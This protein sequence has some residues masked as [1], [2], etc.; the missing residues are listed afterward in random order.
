[1]LFPEVNHPSHL[2][3]E[4]PFITFITSII[5]PNQG[6]EKG[7][8]VMKGN[9]EGGL[10]AVGVLSRPLAILSPQPRKRILIKRVIQDRVQAATRVLIELRPDSQF[11]RE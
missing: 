9:P 3:P 8:Q 4:L 11:H 1:M 10:Q 7:K 5:H 2:P 6:I